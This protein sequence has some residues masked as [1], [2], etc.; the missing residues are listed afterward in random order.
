MSRPP[1]NLI[2]PDRSASGISSNQDGQ[3]VIA[4]T[5]RPDG[6]FRPEIK[7]RPGYTPQEDVSLFRSTKQK[8]LDHHK[9]TKGTVPGLKPNAMVQ[10]ALRGATQ[11]GG[12]GL[13]RSQKKNAKRKEKETGEEVKDSWDNDDEEEGESKSTTTG[14][15][16]N[17][18]LPPPVSDTTTSI[19]T[20]TTEDRAKRLRNLKKKL[21][22]TQQLREKEDGGASLGDAEKEKVNK[23]SEL[24]DEIAKLEIA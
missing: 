18:K 21:K 7:V 4:S 1:M 9:A 13:S 5:R 6:T 19:E 22:Q 16:T 15:E 2:F 11:A 10:N 8:E 23:M 14:K 20:T 12:G 3:R 24:E 17:P